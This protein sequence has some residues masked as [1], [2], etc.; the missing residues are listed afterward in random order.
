MFNIFFTINP[1][2]LEDIDLSFVVVTFWSLRIFLLLFAF[3]WKGLKFLV[4]KSTITNFDLFKLFIKVFFVK[5]TKSLSERIS[6]AD[7]HKDTKR[8]RRESTLNLIFVLSW[9]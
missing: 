9:L 4:F 1:I 8:E 5:L 6:N 7:A 2:P 3:F